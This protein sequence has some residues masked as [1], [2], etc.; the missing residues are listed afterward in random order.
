MQAFVCGALHPV[1]V[2]VHAAREPCAERRLAR[3]GDARET[4]LIEAEGGEARPQERLL[5]VIGHSAPPNFSRHPE[6]SEGS[7]AAIESW[8]RSFTSF[9]MTNQI[10]PPSRLAAVRITDIGERCIHCFPR[11]KSVASRR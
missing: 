6:R 5:F 1:H 7:H 2:G 11:A 8:V 3:R 10:T 4:H 9:R